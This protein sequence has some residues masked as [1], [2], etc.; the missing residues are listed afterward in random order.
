MR[1]L[2]NICDDSREYGSHKAAQQH[3][4]PSPRLDA[5]LVQKSPDRGDELEGAGQKASR[6]GAFS[7]RNMVK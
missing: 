4:I 2:T 3:N 6:V 5:W 7:L 1:K